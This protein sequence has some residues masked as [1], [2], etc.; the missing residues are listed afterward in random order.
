MWVFTE[1]GFFAAVEYKPAME[2][3]TTKQIDA[4]LDADADLVMVRTRAQ[5]DMR[6]LQEKIP[7]LKYRKTPAADYAFRAVLPRSQWAAYLVDATEQMHYSSYK[8][9]AEA[10]VPGRYS[11]LSGIWSE[12]ARLQ[13]QP[14][15]SG[16]LRW[17]EARY[18]VHGQG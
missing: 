17:W 11:W 5:S 10:K 8:K 15:W 3:H 4:L 18:D 9:G 14:P 6:R 12:I 16:K 7:G 13:A 2:E 1:D